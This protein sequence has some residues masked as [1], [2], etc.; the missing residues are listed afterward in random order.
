MEQCP[1]CAIVSGKLPADIVY[2]DECALAFRDINPQAP[3][4]VLVV[5][6]EHVASVDAV[7][8]LTLWSRLM[9]SLRGVVEKLGLADQGYRIVVNCGEA[10]GQTV[11]HLHIHLLA[12]RGLQ[13]PPG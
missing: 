6:K 11:P 1:F 4:H 9:G 3:V 8:D 2:E 13:W 12:G 5:P 10:A 7:A